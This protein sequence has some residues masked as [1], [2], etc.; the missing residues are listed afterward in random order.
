I[1]LG[2]DVFSVPGKGYTIAHPINLISLNEINS[3][4]K[5]SRFQLQ[6]QPI[7]GSTNDELKQLLAT[8]TP[9]N[10]IGVIAEAQTAGRGR[11]GRAWYSPF[12]ASI[13]ISLYWP[14]ENGFAQAM[15]LSNA[16]GIA[17]ARAL[18]AQGVT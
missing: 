6:V 14:L 17:V 5:N 4:R 16:S 15:G 8:A 10:L 2:V 3:Y 13:Y 12:G 9:E 18:E 7:V 11:R 1:E